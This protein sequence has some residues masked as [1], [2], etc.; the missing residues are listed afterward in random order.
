MGRVMYG[1]SVGILS[2][3]I[4]RYM[5]EIVPSHRAALFGGLYTFSFA[6]AVIIAFVMAFG[7]PED[8]INGLPNPEL[9]HD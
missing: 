6:V 4:P 5:D 2:C 9:E 7:L 8:E 1:A 3:A